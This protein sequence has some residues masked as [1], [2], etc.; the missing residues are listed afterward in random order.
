MLLLG[1][2]FQF[3]VTS[4]QDTLPIQ[5]LT[6]PYKGVKYRYTKV[7]VKEKED[8]TAVLQFEY[9]IED[10]GTWKEKVLRKDERFTYH[11]GTILNHLIIETIDS[12][13]GKDLNDN[14]E[15]NSQEPTEE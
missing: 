4:T 10:P 11:I 13:H 15:D 6:G 14:R 2:D 8:D 3:D 5:L 1:H 12:P 7:A 9:A